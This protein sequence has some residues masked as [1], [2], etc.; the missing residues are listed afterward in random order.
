MSESGTPPPGEGRKRWTEQVEVAADQVSE[1]VQE[2]IK[3]GNVRRVI[4]RHEGRNIVDIP[5][6]VATVGGL[7]GLYLAPWLAALAAIA[8]VAA[9]VHVIVEREGEPPQPPAQQGPGQGS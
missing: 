6:T 4:V 3:E 5:L 1:R 7:A 9:R 8:G 2:L